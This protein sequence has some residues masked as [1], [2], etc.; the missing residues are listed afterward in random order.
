MSSPFNEIDKLKALR[1][2]AI[3]EERVKNG[4]PAECPRFKKGDK[5]VLVGLPYH[6]YGIVSRINPRYHISKN[7]DT[8]Y[9]VHVV[10][11]ID[12]VVDWNNP[13]KERRTWN[14]ERLTSYS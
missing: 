14:T 3:K 7:Y 10:S 5:V 12:G 9:L 2:T 6:V 13:S 1:E 11:T 8:T 4:L